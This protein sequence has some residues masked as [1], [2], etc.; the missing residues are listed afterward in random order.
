[1]SPTTHALVGAVMGR[2]AKRTDRAFLAGVASHA[3]LDCLPHRDSG[4]PLILL[5]DACGVLGVAALA[6]ASPDARM[7]AGVAGGVL[8]D[9]E[10]LSALSEDDPG[11]GLKIFPSHWFHHTRHRRGL[12]IGLELLVVAAALLGLSALG[13]TGPTSP[14][15]RSADVIK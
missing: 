3:V 7:L 13:S 12:A 14:S 5:V 4:H 8:P 9:L 10:N 15:Q 2:L 1:M 6:A 11:R